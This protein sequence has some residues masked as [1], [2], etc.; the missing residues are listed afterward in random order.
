M[1]W[2][3]HPEWMLRPDVLEFLRGHGFEHTPEG[4]QRGDMECM[5]V[6]PGNG[7][8]SLDHLDDMVGFH[9]VCGG[10]EADIVAY[11]WSPEVRRPSVRLDTFEVAP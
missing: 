1:S 11:R 3:K 6:C 4:F 9:L 8:W 7:H 2:R 10:D 5:V